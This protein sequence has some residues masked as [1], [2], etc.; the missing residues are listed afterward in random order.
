MYPVLIRYLAEHPQS[1]LAEVWKGTY[2]DKDRAQVFRALESLV[3]K[4][5]LIKD[6]L[7]YSVARQLPTESPYHRPPREKPPIS[8][9]SRIVNQDNLMYF[10]KVCVRAGIKD[11]TQIGNDT[12]ETIVRNLIAGTVGF[13]VKANALNKLSWAKDL[14]KYIR[15]EHNEQQRQERI[16]EENLSRDNEETGDNFADNSSEN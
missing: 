8:L 3:K 12:P 10:A 6:D 7:Y 11:I 4:G 5:F 15:E 2:P 13:Y 1:R 16:R 14:E 9:S